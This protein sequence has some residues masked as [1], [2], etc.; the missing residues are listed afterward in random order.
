MKGIVV[1]SARF[2]RAFR[3]F[4]LAPDASLQPGTPGPK[5]DSDQTSPLQNRWRRPAMGVMRPDL[6]PAVALLFLTF[7][8]FAAPTQARAQIPV[9]LSPAS[10]AFGNVFK[11]T[12]SQP[13][14]VLLT[15][16]QSVPLNISSIGT[17]LPNY[18]ENNNCTT[19]LSAGGSCTISITF[20]PNAITT[21]QG[22][23]SVGDDASTSPQTAAL[24]GYGIQPVTVSPQSGV[25]FGNQVIN[26]SS[27]P[28]TVTV[29]NQQSV[30][31][32]FSSIKAPHYFQQSNNCGSSIPG[33]SS[34]AITLVFTPGAL[35][36]IS[37]AAVIT[38]NAANSPQAIQL[39]G[40]G[41]AASPTPSPSS[42][43]SPSPSSTP[44]PTPTPTPSPTPSPSPTPGTIS[45]LTYHYDNA[46]DGANTNE[47]I[48]A[49]ANVNVDQFGRLFSIPTDSAMYAQPLYVPNVQIPGMAT[50]KVVYV[51]TQH[52]SLY[53]FDADNGST[54]WSVSLGP[55][56][57]MPEGCE[58]PGDVGII[59]TPVIDPSS[60][61]IYAGAAT[62]R[63]GHPMQ[64]LHALD[65]TTGAERSF[66]PVVISAS[67]PGTGSGSQ[68]GFVAFNP[69]TEFQRPSLL[70]NN[71]VLYVGFASH[72]DIGGTVGVHG[73]LFTYDPS[74]LQQ[75]SLF[76]TTPDA[77]FGGIWMSGSGPAADVYN[78]V[79]LSTGN[80]PFDANQGGPD[81]GDSAIK[82]STTSLAVLDYFTPSNQAI[83]ST[84][85]LDLGS[86]GVLLLPDQPTAPIHLLVTGDKQGNVF[87]INRDNMG[88]YS[89]NAN[90]VVQLEKINGG[91]WSTPAFWNNTLYFAA[92]A[93]TP[94]AYPLMNGLLPATPSSRAAEQ[95]RY[96]G[97]I[98]VISANGQANGILWALQHGGTASGNEVLHAYDATNLANEL[99]NSDQAGSRDLP[100]LAGPF[101]E[102]EFESII[103]ANGKVYVP[104][105]QPQ[106]TIFGLLPATES[107]S[108]QRGQKQ[109]FASASSRR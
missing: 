35:G 19:P 64:E 48:L 79:Y 33:N 25:A 77:T 69:L 53:A 43:P 95:F 58:E 86:G 105:G 85:D 65:I 55:Y 52:N 21:F 34:C 74:T 91:I 39:F 50:H 38:D 67:A 81:Y 101:A 20:T 82:L 62:L 71:G 68:N 44:S 5:L 40:N 103:V 11:N 97:A 73:W 45:I 29:T 78:N 12:A 57:P 89:P 63:N 83:L 24:S 46:R 75:T 90:N 27:A 41:V 15:N 31:L 93:S 32:N 88:Q 96:P 80:G 61:T 49:P 1:K 26:T 84:D 47:T 76:L 99:Y 72:C 13:Q 18:V 42:T 102:S 37:E 106:L 51:A 98:P 56:Q 10:L 22:I 9:T 6:R 23:L 30:S 107:G 17:S 66:S 16:N 14:T 54:L 36:P 60:N 109:M 28:Q 2:A 70:L 92:G 7:A 94:T 108:L 59:G 4:R 3:V 8:A 100:G 87:L 104:T